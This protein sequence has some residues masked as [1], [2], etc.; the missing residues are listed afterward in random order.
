MPTSQAYVAG[1]EAQLHA[2]RSPLTVSGPASACACAIAPACLRVAAHTLQTPLPHAA[3]VKRRCAWRRVRKALGTADPSC[4]PYR[5][6]CCQGSLTQ[7][8]LCACNVNS[9]AFAHACASPH[10]HCRI[11]NCSCTDQPASAHAH[12]AMAFGLE[13]GKTLTESCICMLRS[14]IDTRQ[15]PAGGHVSGLAWRPSIGLE[16]QRRYSSRSS[17]FELF[18]RDLIESQYS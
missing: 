5:R 9:L 15:S 17:R 12:V 3:T 10:C 4:W 1:C 18:R 2:H 6:E 13:L 11:L 16:Y 8:L 7:P 14:C